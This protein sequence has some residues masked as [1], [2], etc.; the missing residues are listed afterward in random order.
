MEAGLLRGAVAPRRRGLP[1]DPG[2]VQDSDLTVG[3]RL[4]GASPVWGPMLGLFNQWRALHELPKQRLQHGPSNFHKDLMLVTHS[5]GGF[6]VYFLT[7]LARDLSEQVRN[8]R[9]IHGDQ[10][11]GRTVDSGPIS[12]QI[13]C[14]GIA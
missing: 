3:P 6:W 10:F 1:T 9:R 2:P 8:G 13:L 12:N 4:I 11:S 14:F 7:F 5:P